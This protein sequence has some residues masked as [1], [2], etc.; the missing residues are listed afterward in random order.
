MAAESIK[1]DMNLAAKSSAQNVEG[2]S[3]GKRFISES[4][5]R[6]SSGTARIISKIVL[7]AK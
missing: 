5:M 4:L 3:K 6:K 7:S 1:I 2:L